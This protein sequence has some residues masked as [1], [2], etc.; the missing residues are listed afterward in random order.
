MISPSFPFITGR[1]KRRAFRKY[2][3][4]YCAPLLKASDGSASN[5]RSLSLPFPLS[6]IKR[7]N[8]QP[9]PNRRIVCKF[10]RRGGSG[11]EWKRRRRKRIRGK[12]EMEVEKERERVNNKPFS[13]L[14]E[15]R[16][17]TE[18]ITP[19]VAFFWHFRERQTERLGC[20]P[21]KWWG[22]VKGNWSK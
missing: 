15:R 5:C 19:G 16:P 14:K 7:G 17:P 12:E 22:G 8:Q 10:V 6:E 18:K 9:P 11:T 1:T 13:A 4:P 20:E 3:R 2:P 21:V